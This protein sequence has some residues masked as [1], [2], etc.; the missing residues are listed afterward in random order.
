MCR[1]GGCLSGYRSRR[2]RLATARRPRARRAALPL[3]HQPPARTTA[4]RP[5]PRS[6]RRRGRHAPNRPLPPRDMRACTGVP[7]PA[8]TRSR[9]GR[10]P[11]E[12]AA[13]RTLKAATSAHRQ[14]TCSLTGCTCLS[15]ANPNPL[16]RFWGLRC[17]RDMETL[18]EDDV[19]ESLAPSARGAADPRAMLRLADSL[20]AGDFDAQPESEPVDV[21]EA[22][23]VILPAHGRGRF[24]VRLRAPRVAAV[25]LAVLGAGVS[26]RLLRRPGGHDSL[27]TGAATR[28][29]ASP[30]ARRG[31]GLISARRW[32]ERS[33]QRGGE[34]RR[35]TI[36]HRSGPAKG[37][38]V[39][40]GAPD[41]GVRTR[42]GS[43]PP[44]S[45]SAT[46]GSG[47]RSVDS[48]PASTRAVV[49]SSAPRRKPPCLPGTLGC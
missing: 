5:Q 33:P 9:P 13:G 2:W 40:S 16:T 1:C 39:V 48:A 45:E 25:T 21:G 38:R 44:R 27:R 41:A 20:G 10:E 47:A 3:R 28:H 26:V 32:T 35:G 24:P 4:R 8:A 30:V 12:P 11:S 14:L 15:W 7:D 31:P 34:W 46:R 37:A 18:P 6:A 22:V 49:P 17:L 42:V 43:A 36:H 29:F 23:T 19:Y